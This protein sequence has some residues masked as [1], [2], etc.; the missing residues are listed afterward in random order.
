M[1]ILLLGLAPAALERAQ[2]AGPEPSV[3]EVIR[4]VRPAIVTIT[5]PNGALG[6]GFVVGAN[7]LV[8]TARHVARAATSIT[9]QLA[10]GSPRPATVSAVHPDADLALLKIAAPAP[11]PVLALG[12]SERLEVGEWVVAIGNPFGLGI[13]ASAGIVGAL[14]RSLGSAAAGL[15]QIDAAINPGNSGGPLVNL[16]GQ[17]VGVASAAVTVGQ[18]L[19]F[20]VPIHLARPLLERAR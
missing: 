12:D 2:P 9:V 1:T 4:Q 20:A 16:K 8:L 19:G 17:V 14:G 11:L 15:V 6:S 7:G 3:V 13:T 10:S 5:A 18:G